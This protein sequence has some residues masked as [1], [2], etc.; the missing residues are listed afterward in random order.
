MSEHIQARNASQA[1]W[2]LDPHAIVKPGDPWFADLDRIVPREHYGIAHR[3]K[4][5]L[6]AGAG[7][8]E[9]VHV[10]LMGHAGIGKTTLARN[11]LAELARDGI[12]P[13]YI[14]ALEAFDQGDFVFSDLMLVVAEAIIRHLASLEIELASDQLEAVRRW[15]ADEVLFETHRDQILGSLET[16]AAGGVSLPFLAEFAAKL[17]AALKSDNEYRREIRRRTQR[18]P[19]DLVRRINLLLDAVH[20]GLAQ[21]SARL[22]VVFDNL[23]KTRLELVDRAVLARSDEFRRL[24]TNALLFF[25]PACEYSPLSTPASRAF[26]CINVPVLPVRYPG[27]DPAEVRPEAAKAIE[28]LLEHRLRL[29]AVFVDPAA[30]VLALS[31]W[32]G[33]HIRDMLMIARRAVE[34]V[35]P[36]AVTVQDI[37]KAGRWLG[38]RRTS[39]LR[40]EDF[41]RA[42]EIHQTNR[43]L[44]TDQDRRMLKNSCVLAYDGVEWWD[45]HPGIRADELFLRALREAK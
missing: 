3:L 41:A 24:R 31:H 16:S 44:N 2:T 26:E 4:K 14:N 32:S 42:V 43:I 35:E 10:G 15:F 1:Y 9:F 39:S 20:E 37:E 23:E 8:P 36:D 6:G 40:P 30:C 33:G 7:R 38:G 13:V 25:N 22:C 28:T 34:N 11:A 19:G 21:R 5:Q 29:D 45:V 17:T 18:D 12:A 27:D